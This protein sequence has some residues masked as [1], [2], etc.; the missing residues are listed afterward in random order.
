MLFGTYIDTLYMDTFLVLDKARSS[1]ISK[2][3][4][5]SVIKI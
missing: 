2:M 5:W 3:A 4:I 1:M